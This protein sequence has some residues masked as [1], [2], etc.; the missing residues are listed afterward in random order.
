MVFYTLGEIVPTI[1][2]LGY[3]QNI[4]LFQVDFP[5]P[6]T[7]QEHRAEEEEDASAYISPMSTIMENH[8]ASPDYY[9]CSEDSGV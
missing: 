7:M 6:A 4:S 1:T 5:L 3:S 2:V 9:S 8:D